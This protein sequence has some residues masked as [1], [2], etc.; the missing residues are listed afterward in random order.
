METDGRPDWIAS[1]EK[2][3][4]IAIVGVGLLGGSVGLA[5]RKRKLASEVI[6]IGRRQ[7]SLKKAKAKGAITRSTVDLARGV[8]DA[9]LVVVATPVAQVADHVAEVA[10]L[11]SPGT[12]VTDVGSTKTEIV[13]ALKGRV[14]KGVHFIGSHPLAGGTEAGC[15]N[16]AADLFVGRPVVITPS[17]TTSTEQKERLSQFWKSL[18]GELFEMTPQR[19]DRAVATTSHLTHLVA[20]ALAATTSDD[21]LP[22]TST[23]WFDTTRV[24]SGDVELWQQIVE[25][26]QAPI[27]KSLEKFEKVISKLRQAVEQGDRR[28]IG[29]LLEEAKRKRDAVGN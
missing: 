24:A 19:H 17:R 29:R 1:M 9:D 20:S 10:Q 14:P 8:A 27:A 21:D 7:A 6:G 11:V 3:K 26:N 18:G 28:R 16:A 12:L 2:F 15:E 22:L 23:G 5:V 25:S 4:T 13:A